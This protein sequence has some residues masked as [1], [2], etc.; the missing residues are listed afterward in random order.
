MS[1]LSHVIVGPGK[2]KTCRV[3]QQAG[4]PGKA[5]SQSANASRQLAKVLH[6]PERPVF[7]L[8]TPSPGGTRPATFEG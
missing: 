8:F 3:D 7:V 1:D 4:D 6:L 5:H 2:T